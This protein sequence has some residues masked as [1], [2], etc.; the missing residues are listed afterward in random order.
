MRA[1]IPLQS[2]ESLPDLGAVTRGNTRPL[3]FDG[4]HAGRSAPI[5]AEKVVKAP[6]KGAEKT[7]EKG[8]EKGA[9]KGES[10]GE[11]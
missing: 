9:E 1:A 11:E 2:D 10:A 3:V 4:E 6:E 5:P 8:A 7:P